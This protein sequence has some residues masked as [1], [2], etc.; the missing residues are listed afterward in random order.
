MNLNK[1]IIRMKSAQEKTPRFLLYIFFLQFAVL[2]GAFANVETVLGSVP[3]TQNANLL[4]QIP[5][6]TSSEI[7]IS[8]DQHVL[9]Y[10]KQ[11]RAPNWV[12]WKLEANQIGHSGRT[13]NF[14]QDT[15]LEH[16]LTQTSKADHAVTSAEYKGSCF[17]RGHHET[18]NSRCV[19]R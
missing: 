2:N 10:N 9:S 18:S 19:D 17:D 3:L 13:N 15:D 1:G 12:A 8:R 14:L 5:G 6:T 4:E 11:R 7:I 16:Y